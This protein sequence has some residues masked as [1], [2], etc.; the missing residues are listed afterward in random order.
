MPR[1]STFSLFPGSLFLTRFFRFSTAPVAAFALVSLAFGSGQTARADEFSVLAPSDP[2]VRQLAQISPK[3][4]AAGKPAAGAASLTRYEAALQTARAILD[5]QNR[6]A[7]EAVGATKDAAT[8]TTTRAQWRAIDALCGSLKNELRRLGIDV[9]ATRA[10]AAKNL[11]NSEKSAAKVGESTKNSL[12]PPRVAATSRAAE[13][14]ASR[15][16]ARDANSRTATS[17]GAIPRG[18]VAGTTLLTPELVTNSSAGTLGQALANSTGANPNTLNGGLQMRLLPGLR[19]ATGLQT[20]P[21]AGEESLKNQARFAPDSASLAAQAALSY[22][23]GRYLTLRAANSRLN[24]SD[25]A[26]GG[27]RNPLLDA[28]VFAGARG[29]SGTGGSVDLNLGAGL[30]FSTEIE[31]LRAD[32]GALA[33]RIGGGASLSAFQNRL[34]LQ[35]SLSRLLPGDKSALTTTAAQVGASLDVSPRLSLNLRYQGLFAPTPNLSAARV[36]GGVSLSF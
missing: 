8:G 28:P 17:R 13:D 18:V 9:E 3:T 23:L 27:A 34:L 35:M 21:R 1:F 22:D 12:L 10:L 5:I 6:E 15:N 19:V 2:I 7:G 32:T 31:R 30:K 29:A 24:W 11:K 26:V 16:A 33:S 25:T 36:A 4:G 20:T 14:A